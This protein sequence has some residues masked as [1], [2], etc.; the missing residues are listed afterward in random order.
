MEKINWTFTSGT[1]G[2]WNISS[3]LTTLVET[4]GIGFQLDLR[5]L[6]SK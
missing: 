6:W 4:E 1:V 5:S 3:N 2:A